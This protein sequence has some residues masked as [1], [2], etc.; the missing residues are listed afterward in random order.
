MKGKYYGIST[1]MFYLQSKR[2][3]RE[4]HHLTYLQFYDIS[5]FIF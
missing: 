5:I 3:K 2:K 1:K 4:P